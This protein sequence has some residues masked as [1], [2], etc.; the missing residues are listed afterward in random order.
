MDENHDA[1]ETRCP[2]LGHLVPFRYCRRLNEGLPCRRI[3]GCWQDKID[4]AAFVRDN[5]TREEIDRFM[6]PA[7]PK[8]TQIV[9]LIKQARQRS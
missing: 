8:L 4:A 2:M 6:A 9:E 5:Y 7:P 3:V 1:I